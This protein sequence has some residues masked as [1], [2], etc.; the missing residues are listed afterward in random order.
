MVEVLDELCDGF[1]Y[2]IPTVFIADIAPQAVEP[3]KDQL[4]AM[5][6]AYSLDRPCCVCH[7]LT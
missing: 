4:T 2:L 1:S 6:R 5:A 3:A 7:F